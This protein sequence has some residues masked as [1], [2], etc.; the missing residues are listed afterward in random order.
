MYRSRVKRQAGQKLKDEKAA[1]AKKKQDERAGEHQKELPAKRRLV[2]A[3]LMQ[4]V[5]E[6]LTVKNM[7]TYL[8][9]NHSSAVANKVN[10]DNVLEMFNKCSGLKKIFQTV[11]LH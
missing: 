6:R 4:T 7:K 8:K 2:K 3:G 9:N 10:K 1:A 5:N 11:S